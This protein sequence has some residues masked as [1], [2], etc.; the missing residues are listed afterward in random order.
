ME[1]D[2]PLYNSKRDVAWNFRFVVEEVAR[3]LEDGRWTELN[4]AVIFPNAVSSDELGQAAESFITFVAGAT[5]DPK[6]SMKDVLDRSGFTDL[7]PGAQVAY[8]A[9]LG[10][11]MSGIY[12]RGAR[13]VTLGGE[14]PCSN[15]ADLLAA[16]REAHRLIAAPRWKRPWLRLKNKIGKAFHGFRNG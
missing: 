8:M 2:T 12:F 14:G 11:V 4:N 1:K 13:E 15:T 3:R 9:T 7:C 10:V 6:E 5:A 16:G